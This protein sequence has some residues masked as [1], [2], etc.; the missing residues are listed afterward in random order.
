ML[1]LA[2]QLKE[3]DNL[4][5]CLIICGL[6]ILKFNWKDEVKKHTNL[7]CTILGEKVTK[8][9]KTIIGSVADRVSHLKRQ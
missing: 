3:R 4:E 2:S 8:T 7:S 6:N 1:S 5:H 9:G